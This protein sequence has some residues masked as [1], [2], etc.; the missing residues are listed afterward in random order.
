MVMIV[1]VRRTFESGTLAGVVV[2]EQYRIDARR[3]PKVGEVF[4]VEHPVGGG[5]PYIDEIV[6]VEPWGN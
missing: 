5:S 6:A 1:K 3:A 4:A 2:R